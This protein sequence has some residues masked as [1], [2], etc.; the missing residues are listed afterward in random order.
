MSGVK[1][2]LLT[3]EDCQ[4]CDYVKSKIESEGFDVEIV[5]ED[6][7]DGKVLMSYHQIYLMMDKDRNANFP[8]LI[9][10]NGQGEEVVTGS[11]NIV[12]AMRS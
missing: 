1:L 10:E 6:S 12:K 2:T 8:F 5:G 4:K 11:I 7:V 9:K 3:K